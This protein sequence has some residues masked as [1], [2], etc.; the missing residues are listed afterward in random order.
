MDRIEFNPHR[1]CPKSKFEI[2]KIKGGK[3]AELAVIES[4]RIIC[5]RLDFTH[6][7]HLKFTCYP[8]VPENL[9]FV[10]HVHTS[11]LHSYIFGFFQAIY[12]TYFEEASDS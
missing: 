3:L 12:K 8:V 2:L 1:K 4:K 6:Q 10:P 9:D 7:A 5:Y 11:K